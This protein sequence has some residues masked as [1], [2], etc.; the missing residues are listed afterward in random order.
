MTADVRR[1]LLIL[2]GL[3]MIMVMVIATSLR[4]LEFQPG[5]PLPKLEN[6]Q[7]VALPALSEPVVAIPVE[8]FFGAFFALV[9]AGSIMYV[10]Y[11]TLIKG[12]QW[13]NMAVFLR[14]MLIIGL[15]AGGFLLLFLLLPSTGGT[16]SSTT[17]PIVP[18]EPQAEAPLGPVPPLVF[19][20]VVIVLMVLCVF[21]GIW[22]LKSSRK[23]SPIELV[24]S[25]AEKARQALINGQELKG[26]IIKCYRQMSLGLEEQRGIKRKDFMT[27][28][29]FENLLETAGIPHEPIH[30][31]TRLFEAVRYGNWQPNPSDEQSAIQCLEAI[32]TYSRGIKG[33]V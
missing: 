15:I 24:E 20:L 18:V 11:K 8:N 26:V 3:A 14:R 6:N 10:L 23:K 17:L 28:G 16:T 32:L 2:F 27:T 29:E 31:L 33:A 25:E 19:W 7:V 13:K 1:R 4:R 9:L 12:V 5:M 22:I 21:A 30:Q